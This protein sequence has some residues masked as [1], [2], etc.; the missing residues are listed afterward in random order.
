MVLWLFP[1]P[2]PPFQSLIC[3]S[4][5]SARPVSFLPPLS[6][7]DPAPEPQNLKAPLGPSPF[8][9]Q[10]LPTLTPPEAIVPNLEVTQP[11]QLES[12]YLCLGNIAY[13]NSE[14]Q[15]ASP[16]FMNLFNKITSFS[17]QPPW[18]QVQV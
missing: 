14:C 17:Q 16:N 6:A 7:L 10:T 12:N 3:H 1:V 8:L 9:F 13:D 18:I 2:Q 4:L 5:L 15:T 11:P